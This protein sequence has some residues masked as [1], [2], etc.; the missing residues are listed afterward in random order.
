MRPF[1][2]KHSS[3][4]AVVLILVVGLVAGACDGDGSTASSISEQAQE[5]GGRGD[6]SAAQE[7]TPPETEAP[8]ATE[9]PAPEEPETESETEALTVFIILVVV[10]LIAVLIGG[11]IGGRSRKEQPSQAAAPV[12]DTSLNNMVATANWL[13]DSA[14]LEVLSSPADQVAQQWQR[15]RPRA[16]DLETQASSQ[17]MGSASA[18]LATASTGLASVVGSLTSSLDSYVTL[19]QRQQAGEAVSDEL[20][21]EAQNSVMSRRRD[22]QAAVGQ[23]QAAR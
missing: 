4:L 1:N 19:R 10:L 21:T 20:I 3:V 8:P 18:Q 13:H 12:P 22:L 9:A 2:L 16:V 7:E 14:S 15:V 6:D 5:G 23:V 11:L 17:A